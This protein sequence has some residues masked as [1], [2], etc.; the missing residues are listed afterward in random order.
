M[1]E[2][3][4]LKSTGAGSRSREMAKR[5]WIETRA[6]LRENAEE[7]VT[8]LMRKAG[9]IEPR[10]ALYRKTDQNRANAKTDPYALNA[11]CWQV[12]AQANERDLRG[13]YQGDGDQ[14]ALLNQVAK[15]SPAID[16]PAAGCRFPSQARHCRGNSPA[17]TQNTPGRRRDESPWED[18]QSLA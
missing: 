3:R 13:D 4:K 17:L 7:L 8:C 16:G 9:C 14:A 6:N 18:A 15:L 2:H 11:W 5:D 1:R 12:L 10:A